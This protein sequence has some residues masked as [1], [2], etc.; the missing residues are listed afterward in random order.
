MME[1]RGRKSAPARKDRR[2]YA[3][4]SARIN[5][6]VGRSRDSI[7]RNPAMLRYADP[8]T[9]K[10][11]CQHRRFSRGSS[12]GDDWAARGVGWISSI[13]R[14]GPTVDRHATFGQGHFVPVF[15]ALGPR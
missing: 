1:V 11:P 15:L 4:R 10:G 14:N 2:G 8:P 5:E 9:P 7:Q 3:Y 6:F 13:E 12:G